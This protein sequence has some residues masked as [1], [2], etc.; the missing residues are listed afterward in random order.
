M[1]RRGLIFH[2]TREA[3]WAEAQACGTYRRSTRGQTLEDVGFIHCAGAAQVEGVANT[4][5][6]GTRGLVL[7]AIA[8]DRVR[9]EIRYENLT[10]GEE[11][12]PHI[13]GPLD[14]GAVVAVLPFEPGPDGIFAFP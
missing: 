4:I 6:A 5:Y 9:S 3:D 12:F 1:V 7:L 10:G 14:V 13:Y 8:V 11:E 2:L